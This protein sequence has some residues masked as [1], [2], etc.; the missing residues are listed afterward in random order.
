M[1]WPDNKLIRG[2][3]DQ[4]KQMYR[5]AIKYLIFRFKNKLQPHV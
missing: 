2:S 4:V 5:T 1:V 3:T